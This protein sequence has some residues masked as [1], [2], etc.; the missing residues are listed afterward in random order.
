MILVYD[1]MANGT[2]HD[3]LYKVKKPSLSWTRRLTICIGAARGLHYLHTGRV[4]QIIDPYLQGK[5]DPTSLRT[6]IDIARKCLGETGSERPTMGEV[7]WNLEQAWLQQQ[8]SD[9]FQNDG[10]YG[11]ADKTTANG[12]SVIVDVDGVTLHGASD[13]TPGVE[14]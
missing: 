9:C 8:E 5:I 11:V 3:H 1:Y 6:F 14:F 2:L 10:N 12:L 7:L 13:P 4:D